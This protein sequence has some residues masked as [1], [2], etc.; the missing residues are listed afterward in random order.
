MISKDFTLAGLWSFGRLSKG[1]AETVCDTALLIL[2]IKTPVY[3]R[4]KLKNNFK[5][6]D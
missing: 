5:F 3:A 1:N 4:K 2:N 6:L